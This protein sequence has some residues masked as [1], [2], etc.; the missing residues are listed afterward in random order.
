MPA[1]TA[2]LQLRLDALSDGIKVALAEGDSNDFDS[3]VAH[4]SH[5]R[6]SQLAMQV[7]EWRED[8]KTLVKSIDRQL[9]IS[10]E[11]RSTD[12]LKILNNESEMIQST[13]GLFSQVDPS[14][15]Q[16]SDK[17]DELAFIRMLR[18]DL[19]L[20]YEYRLTLHRRCMQEE[21]DSQYDENTDSDVERRILVMEQVEKEAVRIFDGEDGCKTHSL[22][23]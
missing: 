10:R 22:L 17:I 5:T 19:L 23:M 15:S 6:I 9:D 20:L 14:L 18:S 21:R 7:I 8:S 4:F 13:D 3:I 16:K 2:A 12:T 11:L 1:K